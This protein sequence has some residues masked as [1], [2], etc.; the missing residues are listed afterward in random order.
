MGASVNGPIVQFI[1]N[2]VGKAM[3]EPEG[4]T[5]ENLEKS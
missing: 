4:Y 3:A 5:K 1:N 2:I